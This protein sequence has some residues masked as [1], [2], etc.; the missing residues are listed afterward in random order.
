MAS[1]QE[2]ILFAGL[3]KVKGATWWDVV[4]VVDVMGRPA[5]S[6]ISM[7]TSHLLCKCAIAISAPALPGET[8][9]VTVYV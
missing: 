7:H 2:L 3:D 8:Q 6:V 5:A 4:D 1:C 9:A